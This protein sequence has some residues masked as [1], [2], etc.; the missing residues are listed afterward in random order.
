LE[1]RLIISIILF[2]KLVI[3]VVRTIRG[4]FIRIA[5]FYPTKL[6]NHLGGGPN[7]PKKLM[8]D[9]N[10]K[11]INDFFGAGV[12][13]GLVGNIW[14]NFFPAALIL[15]G[16]ETRTP[17]LDM[18]SLFFKPPELDSTW[19]LLFGLMSTFGVAITNSIIV[20]ALIKFTGRDFAYLKS[21][22]VCSA[23]MMFAFMILYPLLGNEANQ[24]SVLSTFGAFINNQPF[25][26]LIAFLFLKYT[27][28]GLRK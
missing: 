19:A 11:K 22:V 21:I 2:L 6:Q 20:G 25:A 15:M 3:S 8:R 17:A 9:N 18:A 10:M 27:T 26:I 4:L 16:F 12:I 24:H 5:P 23:S 1:V 7:T 13:F 28:V 14:I